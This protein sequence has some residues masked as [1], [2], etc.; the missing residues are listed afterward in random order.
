[1]AY[2]ITF[3]ESTQI[4]CV[5]HSGPTDL[6]L[7]LRSVDEVTQKYAG[8]EEL[9]LLIDVREQTMN[10]LL[11]E[12]EAFG[13]YVANHYDLRRAKVAVLHLPKFNSNSVV[14]NKAIKNGYQ[15]QRFS[16]LPAAMQWLSGS[17][18]SQDNRR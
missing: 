8:L 17:R 16:S 14:D 12:Q 6:D 3:D 1:M 10:M 13:E 5:T 4:I 18:H 11:G 2:T 7:K 9:K 15:L